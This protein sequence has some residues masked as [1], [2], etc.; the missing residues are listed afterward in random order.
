MAM[1]AAPLRRIGF[2]L[3]SPSRRPQPSTRIAVLNILAP[4]RERGLDPVILHDP[5]VAE[6]RPA[7]DGLARRAREAGCAAVVFQKV[8][9]DSALAEAAALRTTG[10][11]T[12]WTVCDVIDPAM[13][14]AVDRTACVTEHLRAC[15]PAALQERLHVVHDGIEHPER[16]KSA[17]SDHRG[18]A[19]RPLRAVLVTSSSLTS[20][21]VLGALPE[22]LELTIV[23]RYAPA[24][25][26]LRR[27][28]EAWWQWRRCRTTAERWALARFLANPRIHRTAWDPHGVYDAI[29][30]ADIGLIPVDAVP[31]GAPGAPEPAWR[32]KSENRLTLLMAAGLPVVASP[33]PAYLPVVRDG[34]DAMLAG[35]RAAWLQALE[36]LRDPALRRAMGRSAREAVLERYS[37]EAQARTLSD[38]IDAALQDVAGGPAGRTG[39]RP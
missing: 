2:V 3:L 9:G 14:R 35:D 24:H 15:Y 37:R 31:P 28:R 26:R 21:P 22:W 11:A 12:V 17:W 8:H 6:E 18:D 1:S 34:Q 10:I 16:V 33:L 20:L 4:L 29:E 39:T 19:R 27:W 25:A 38:V 32:L 7:L 13:A 30:A 36:R 23:G 5:E